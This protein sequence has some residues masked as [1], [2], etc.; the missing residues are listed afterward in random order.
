MYQDLMK[1]R[2]FASHQVLK[3]LQY[4]SNSL[5]LSKM[6]NVKLHDGTIRKDSSSMVCLE[7]FARRKLLL[8][9]KGFDKQDQPEDVWT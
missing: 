6:L 5:S 8:S 2:L 4:I 9:K 3:P 1:K 7:G